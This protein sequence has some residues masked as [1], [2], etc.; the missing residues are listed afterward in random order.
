[1]SQ[2]DRFEFK[3]QVDLEIEG[4]LIPQIVIEF[5]SQVNILL[6]RTWM[7]LGHPK[8]VKFD[9]YLKLTDQSLVKP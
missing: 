8:L 6:K 4:V 7:K 5:S 2:V 3:P 1:M 9:F